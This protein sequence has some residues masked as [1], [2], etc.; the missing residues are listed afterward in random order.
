MTNPRFSVIIPTYNRAHIVSRAIDSVL[1]QSRRDFELIVVDDGSTDNTHDL[2]T[3]INDARLRYIYQPNGGVCA[4][5]NTGAHQASGDYLTF[6]DSDDEALPEW[7]AHFAEGVRGDT[8]GMVCVGSRIVVSKNGQVLKETIELPSQMGVLFEHQVGKF[9]AGTFAIRRDLFE[10]VGGYAEELVYGENTEL[11]IRLV[12]YTLQH[13]WKIVSCKVPLIVY[14]QQPFDYSKMHTHW[15][16]RLESVQYTLHHHKARFQRC[17]PTRSAYLGGAG[18]CAARL[19]QMGQARRYF[20]QA[21]LARPTR[22]RHYVRLG[23][24]LIPSL[25]R[26]YWLRHES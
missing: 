10:A 3:A 18:V 17:A 26:K 5:R 9:L 25:A 23:L 2:I 14:Y 21:I 22:W 16:A 4:A 1:C 19:G 11:A 6:L 7:L 15:Q 8:V 12:S 24:T 13:N 20:W